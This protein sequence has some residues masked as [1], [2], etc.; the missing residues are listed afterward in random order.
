MIDKKVASEINISIEEMEEKQMN[1][2]DVATEVLSKVGGKAN[3]KDVTHCVT[4]LRFTLADVKKVDEDALK[5]IDGV[6]GSINKG[7]SFQVVIGNEVG[8]VYNELIKLGDFSKDSSKNENSEKLSIGSRVMDVI[9]D[10][11]APLIPAIAGAG[12]LK[13]LLTLVTTFNLMPQDNS[14][15]KLLTVMA[16]AV[17]YFTIKK[18]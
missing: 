12:M 5:E 17:F 3:V 14:T 9:T 10:S 13:V 1:Y 15:F 18:I 2:K 6:M 4:R 7:G 16:D 8:N 11:F